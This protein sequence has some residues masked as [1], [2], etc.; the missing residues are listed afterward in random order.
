MPD[1]AGE[2]NLEPTPH[3]RQQ[4]RQDGHVAKSHDLGSAGMLF[5]GL[6]VLMMLGG[7]LVTFLIDYCRTQLG[8]QAWLSIDADFVTGHWNATL[9]ALGRCLLPILGLLCLAAVVVNVLQIGFLFLPQRLSA[10]VERL[11]PLKGLQRIFSG[12]S[13][14]R[15]TFGVFK[16]IVILSVSCMVL[17]NQREALLG[18]A[19]LA[20]PALAVQMTHI[21]FWAA[22]KVGAALLVLAML[23]Y[24]YQRW[25]HERDMRMTP[26]ELREELKNLEGNPQVIARRKQMQRELSVDPLREVNISIKPP[27]QADRLNQRKNAI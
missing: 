6:A 4:V 7:S 9:G 26:Q 1:Y 3:R 5:L 17:Y 19:G 16:L 23:D 22:L 27:T 15:L 21:L 11:S 8:G 10:D 24:A 2:K 12:A 13:L 25:Q 14:A 18:L 20:P